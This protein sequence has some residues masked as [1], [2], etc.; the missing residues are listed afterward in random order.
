MIKQEELPECWVNVMTVAQLL[1]CALADAKL[2]LKS[3]ALRS[4]EHIP[5]SEVPE[6]RLLVNTVTR[7]YDVRVFVAHGR[8][9]ES[10]D[11]AMKRITGKLVD[12][13][14]SDREGAFRK[15]LC[16]P[17]DVLCEAKVHLRAYL[18]QRHQDPDY[19][20]KLLAA[21]QQWEAAVDRWPQACKDFFGPHFHDSV[22]P[23][24]RNDDKVVGVMR[25][26]LNKLVVGSADPEVVRAL[27]LLADWQRERQGLALAATLLDEQVAE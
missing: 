14:G 17:I 4:G 27:H 20:R 10:L 1:D 2:L 11:S 23:P 3:G 25:L 5:V 22:V 12:P 26:L 13:H 16:R 18:E 7:I 19:A 8:H 21:L 6:E 24:R 9:D 15:D